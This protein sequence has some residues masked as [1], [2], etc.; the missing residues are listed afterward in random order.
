MGV[1]ADTV[2]IEC[3]ENGRAAQSIFENLHIDCTGKHPVR[4]QLGNEH[5]VVTVRQSIRG[6]VQDE[7]SPTNLVV[8]DD[9]IA[10]RWTAVSQV[11]HPW[12]KGAFDCTDGDFV[13][14]VL[15]LDPNRNP[16]ISR[17]GWK[18]SD[19][20]WIHTTRYR[21]SKLVVVKRCC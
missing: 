11:C 16:A 19:E 2:E 14:R 8:N 4:R 20:C 6:V 10:I 7:P 13:T 15:P 9:V 1:R 17:N 12:L 18:K 5:L 21:R 3:L